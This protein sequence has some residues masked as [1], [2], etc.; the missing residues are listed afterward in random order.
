MAL[1]RIGGLI[2]EENMFERLIE[3]LIV[4]LIGFT[5]YG[6]WQIYQSPT[7]ELNKAEW[8]CSKNIMRTT[9]IIINGKVMPQIKQECTEY[10]RL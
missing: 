7:I 10:K 6:C 2:G 3:L 4:V 9:S 8:V 1:M 5:V